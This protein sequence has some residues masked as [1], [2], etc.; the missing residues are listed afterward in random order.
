MRAAPSQYDQSTFSGKRFSST[1]FA[2]EYLWSREMYY[3]TQIDPRITIFDIFVKLFTAP[4][5]VSQMVAARTRPG[6]IENMD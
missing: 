2:W 1:D 6:R 4:F 5:G 3:I